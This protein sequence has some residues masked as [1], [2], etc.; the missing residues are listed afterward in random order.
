MGERYFEFRTDVWACLFLNEWTGKRIDG[1][2]TEGSFKR[3]TQKK[4]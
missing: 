1:R 3:L 4:K 2:A